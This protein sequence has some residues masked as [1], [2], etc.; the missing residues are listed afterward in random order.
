[1]HAMLITFESTLDAEALASPFA[2]YAQALR[3]VDG[4]IMKTWINRDQTWGGFHIFTDRASADRYLDS[5]L[6]AGIV[7]NPAFRDFQI[8]HF[9]IVDELSA[10][11]GTPLTLSSALR[12]S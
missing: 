6:L 11:N 1:M 2:D 12:P 7:S 5:E 10:I 3:G 4:L 9:T 8:S